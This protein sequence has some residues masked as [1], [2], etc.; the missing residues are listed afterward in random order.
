[1]YGPMWVLIALLLV[2][3]GAG[4][5]RAQDN[6]ITFQG[7]LKQNGALVNGTPT[8]EFRLYD[9]LVGGNQIGTPI[10]RNAVPVAD[11][12][13]SVDL[14]FGAGA[15]ASGKRF[16]ETVVDGQALS[17]R[18]AVNAAPIATFAISGAPGPQGPIGPA[19]PSGPVGQ[20][21][22]AG[23]SGTT[24][25]I[26]PPGPKGAP[27]ATPFFPGDPLFAGISI[28]DLGQTHLL[29]TR[30]PGSVPG[31]S[32]VVK[33]A[34]DV[35]SYSAGFSAT[36]T[37]GGGGGSVGRIEADKLRVLA[38]NDRASAGFFASLAAG[39]VIARLRIDTLVPGAAGA[40][41]ALRRL[42]TEEVFVVGHRLLPQQNLVLLEFRFSRYGVRQYTA[43]PD[44]T[45]FATSAGW[46]FVSSLPFA[47]ADNADC[48][49]QP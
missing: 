33:D 37:V 43:R 3:F 49:E 28:D 10:T 27:G 29:L 15:F 21:G 9:Q 46:D 13:F 6:S 25:P 17:P 5:A 7:Q 23:P 14:D 1:M 4:I 48:P 11:G 41:R 45:V 24:G 16:I 35:V 47:P 38:A 30:G 34:V 40:T 42:C 31:D 18:Q 32:A 12:L 22:V 2:A 8:L 20:Q 39:Q 44:G 19:G 26:G 36:T